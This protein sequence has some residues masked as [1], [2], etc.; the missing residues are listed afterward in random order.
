MPKILFLLVF[1]RCKA[2]NFLEL[3]AEIALCGKAKLLGNIED[4]G[5][6]RPEKLLCQPDFDA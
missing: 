5:I 2:C 1:S 6:I 4:R 3:L